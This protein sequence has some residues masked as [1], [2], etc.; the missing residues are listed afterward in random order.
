MP[1][2]LLD[3]ILFLCL[4]SLLIALLIGV[5]GTWVW[6]LRRLW[7]RIPLLSGMTVLP[8]R[9]PP[10]ELSSILLA[11]FL[12][13]AVNFAVFNGY[14]SITG[15][16][17]PRHDAAGQ[18]AEALA[19]QDPGAPDRKVQGNGGDD[20]VL[21]GAKSGP[22]K[23][24][25]PGPDAG[26][27]AVQSEGELMLQSAIINVILVFLVPSVILRLSG[28]Q[29]ADLGWDTRDWHRQ[30]LQGVRAALLITPV[31]FTVQN[32][33]VRIWDYRRHLLDE[34]VSKQFTLGTAMLAIVSA[35][36]LAPM[37]EE[38]LF[39]GLLQKWLKKNFGEGSRP[40]DAGNNVLSSAFEDDPFSAVEK[41]VR[42]EDAM[43]SPDL[44]FIEDGDRERDLM[45][46][47]R[48]NLNAIFVTSTLFA[49][50]HYMQ[51]P[52]PIAIFVLSLW[53]GTIYARSRSLITAIALHATFNS[54]STTVLLLDAVGRRIGGVG[55]RGVLDVLGC[56][57]P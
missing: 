46:D 10:W 36:L 48:A 57:W 56:F 35:M 38:M 40:S 25:E 9:E 19:N 21:K 55:P 6:A 4:M 53:L 8:A 45:P 41:D 12:Y 37:V 2:R 43:D 30:V 47:P 17:L 28:A 42:L 31:V 14:Q 54:F 3:S 34:M 52:A 1:V 11:V 15:R 29:L 5:I 24:L 23:G 32:L 33:A 50:M 20:D 22:P 16:R 13:L 7:L 26:D 18:K 49:G 27:G 51:W 39:R 44:R